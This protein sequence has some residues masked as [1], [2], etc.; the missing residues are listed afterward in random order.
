M[1]HLCSYRGE[2]GKTYGEL[3]IAQLSLGRG[4]RL[5]RNILSEHM[6]Y[7]RQGTI[8]RVILVFYCIVSQTL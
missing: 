5:N 8:L 2:V 3:L 7:L 4:D 1:E 6:F